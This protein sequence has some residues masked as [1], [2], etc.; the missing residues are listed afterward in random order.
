M[1]KM[2]RKINGNK[3]KVCGGGGW[4]RGVAREAGKFHSSCFAIGIS[5]ARYIGAR[6]SY[7]YLVRLAV[8]IKS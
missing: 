2:G 1:M 4:A 6:I 7:D 8:L 3:I 5:L